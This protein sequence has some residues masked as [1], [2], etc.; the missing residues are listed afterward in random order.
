MG[1]IYDYKCPACGGAIEFDSE[2][3]NMKCPYCDTEID[4][5][6]VAK[7]V[8]DGAVERKDDEYSSF[9]SEGTNEW[10]DGET[11]NMKVY[12]CDSCG[13]E[14]IA[15]DTTG[16]AQ[17]PFCGSKLVIKE[18]FSGDLR[19][20]YIIP[21][22]ISKQEAKAKYHEHLK[23]KPFLPKIFKSENHIDEMKGIY[24]PFWLFDADADADVTYSAERVR[25]WT[26]G[27]KRYTE[28]KKYRIERE[29]SM[30]FSNI[31]SDSST[32]IDNVL[33]ESIEP[34]DFSQA[35]PFN[36]AYLAG[37]AADRYDVEKEDCLKRLSDR[38]KRSSEDYLRETVTGDYGIVTCQHSKVDIKNGKYKYVLYPVWNLNTRWR[39]KKYVFALN[40]QT[41][42]TVGDLP[43]DMGAYWRFVGAATAIASAVI[44][45]VTMLLQLL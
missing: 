12:V 21:F 14:I 26:T 34:F 39:D 7:D 3:Q 29:G 43:A 40:G 10:Q 5:A 25:H 45:G 38:I 44:F 24:V 4:I 18:Q 36:P 2:T 11:D 31:P 37:Y 9:E 1:T 27:N 8:K 33:T 6:S 19:P 17:C 13:G 28:V 15:D 22:K 23:G 42:K 32:K 41:G 16:A 35:V 20:D 30:E